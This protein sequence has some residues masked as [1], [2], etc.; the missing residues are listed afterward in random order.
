MN[1]ESFMI[2]CWFIL[3]SKVAD[4]CFPTLGQTTSQR[5]GREECGSTL[6]PI[7]VHDR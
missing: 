2:T 1:D 5:I 7:E 4:G 6:R 3:D